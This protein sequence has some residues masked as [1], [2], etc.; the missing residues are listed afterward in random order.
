[1]P[2]CLPTT[3]LPTTVPVMRS[4]SESGHDAAPASQTDT[5]G[6]AQAAQAALTGN[7]IQLVVPND[8][9]RMHGVRCVIESWLSMSESITAGFVDDLLLVVSELVTNAME[10]SAST[11]RPVEVTVWHEGPQLLLCVGDEGPGP[12]DGDP[13]VDGP[14]NR[15]RGRGLLIVAAV[16]DDVTI[17]REEGR[18]VATARM[19]LHRSPTAGAGQEKIAPIV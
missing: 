5:A 17:E 3:G 15:E 6:A 16:M 1:M 11:G 13:S 18:T 14:Y 7:S 8:L 19:T 10:A 2:P 9:A 12:P 4:A